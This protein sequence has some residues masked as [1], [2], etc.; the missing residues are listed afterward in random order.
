MTIDASATAARR[1]TRYNVVRIATGLVLLVAATLK[2]YYLATEPIL[3]E[4]LLQSRWLLI[5]VVEGELFLALWLFAGIWPTKSF[6]L[7]LLCFFVFASVS[8]IKAISGETNC[9]C[10]GSVE[11]HPWLTFALST[12]IVIALV[13][14]RPTV[15]AGSF[16]QGIAIAPPWRFGM[17]LAIWIVMGIPAAIAMGNGHFAK[18][19][20]TGDFIGSSDI[21]PLEPYTWVGNKFAVAKHIDIGDKLTNGVWIVL[22]FK[23]GCGSCKEAVTQYQKLGKAFT[24]KPG[25]HRLR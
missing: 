22:F 6:V 5:T 7:A 9:G 20:L 13:A 8:F 25:A 19:S 21:V 10:F 15:H 24:R 23:H 1:M 14:T 18:L 2:A 16:A 12:T 3:G 11:V 4:G 17:V